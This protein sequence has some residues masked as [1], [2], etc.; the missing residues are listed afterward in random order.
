MNPNKQVAETM[1]W[2]I[3]YNKNDDDYTIF[4]GS[5]KRNALAYKNNNG[6]YDQHLWILKY[7]PSD[8]TQRWLFT[9]IKINSAT[10]NTY[11]ISPPKTP[12]TA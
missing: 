7:N 9:H 6:N 11:V 12:I 4:L 2:Y 1:Q 10:D 5:S 8:R 3:N